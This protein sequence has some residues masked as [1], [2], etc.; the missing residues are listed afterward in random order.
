MKTAVTMVSV[1]GMFAEGKIDVAGFIGFCAELGVDGADLAEY[2]W[3]NRETEMRDAVSLLQ[4]NNLV[5]SAYAIG[6]A[7][8]ITDPLKLQK[9]LD[10]VKNA[11]DTAR[12]LGA[13]KLRVFGGSPIPGFTRDESLNKVIEG[14]GQCLPHAEEA[15]VILAL[16]N[17]GDMPG[18]SD[19]LL[20]AVKHFNSPN[21]RINID[22]ANFRGYSMEVPENPAQAVRKLLPYTVHAHV[23]DF[24][25]F[26]GGARRMF[27][28]ILGEGVVALEDCLR[29]MKNGGYAGFLSLEFEGGRHY[30]EK[31]GV[32]KS[33]V[34]LKNII[35]GLG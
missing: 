19:E 5:L 7:F 24:A 28:C 18:R 35:G 34:N 12:A 6:N 16:E 21:L 29:E 4:D 25:F 27:G 17:H 30:D 22:I 26:P 10:Y 14:L 11:I 8:T 33:I 13:D 9:Q 3:K 23:K 31:E 2:Y 15:G 1:G 32:K 20:K